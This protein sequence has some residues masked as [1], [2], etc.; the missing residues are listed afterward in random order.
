MFD[1]RG[2]IVFDGSRYSEAT[3]LE[4]ALD[5]G[6]EDLETEEDILT[7]YADPAHFDTVQ[8]ALRARSL[9]WESAELAMVPKSL[10]R[11]EGKDA[12]RLVK[13]LD[14]LE[15]SDDVQKVYTNADIDEDSLVEA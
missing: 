1:H 12:E 2:Q 11:V 3:L 15:E 10:I 9:Q 4:A 6:A 13:L 5:A 14:A 7:V 8:R